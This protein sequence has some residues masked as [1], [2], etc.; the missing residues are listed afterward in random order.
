MNVRTVVNPEVLQGPTE[1]QGTL[2]ENY[3]V[4]MD[5]MDRVY[6][7]FIQNQQVGLNP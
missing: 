5:E 4:S 3:G 6:N 1:L 2:T 7:A